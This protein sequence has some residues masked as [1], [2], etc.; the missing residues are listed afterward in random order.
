MKQTGCWN[1]FREKCTNETLYHFKDINDRTNFTMLKH[2]PY[3]QDWCSL[4]AWSL[5][6][7]R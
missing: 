4:C 3:F 1:V 5:H 7:F 2:I 6:R